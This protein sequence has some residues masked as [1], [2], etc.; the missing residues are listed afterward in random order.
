MASSSVS[1][2]LA[3]ALRTIPL[4]FEKASLPLSVLSRH[5][6]WMKPKGAEDGSRM[7]AAQWLSRN[8]P[9]AP[10]EV[11]TAKLEIGEKSL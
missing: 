11:P 6:C 1:R 8:S 4:I 3:S 5:K 9:S 10:M 7:L 2:V